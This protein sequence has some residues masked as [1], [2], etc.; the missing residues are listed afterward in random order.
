MK[1][2]RKDRRKEGAEVRLEGGR[3]WGEIKRDIKTKKLQRKEERR[4][5]KEKNWNRKE[6][7]KK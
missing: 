4:K 6:R 7:S 2:R 1:E 3:K 5:G